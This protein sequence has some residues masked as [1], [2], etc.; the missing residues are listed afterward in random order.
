MLNFDKNIIGSEFDHSVFPPVTGTQIR[1]YAESAGD[2]NPRYTTADDAELIAPPTFVVSLRGQHFMPS[3]M[4]N[5]G[6]NG[7]DA[8]KDIDFGV[9]VRVGDVLTAS[10]T[11]HDIYE[12]TGRSGSMNF[13]VLRT[14]VTN[15]R[16]ELVA[17]IDQKMMFR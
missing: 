2:C 12:K 10:S 16:G 13:I 9:P 6:R 1:E 7:F 11:V 4:P 15:Q 14:V 17:T 8:G 5:L 3:N